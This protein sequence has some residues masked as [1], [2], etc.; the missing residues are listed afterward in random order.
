MRRRPHQPDL[1]IVDAGLKLEE[2]EPHQ[3]L[4][5]LRGAERA[6]DP[7]QFFLLRAATLH[8]LSRFAEAEADALRSLAVAPDVATTHDLL[9]RVRDHLGDAAGAAEAAEHAAELDPEEFPTPLEIADE[10]FDAMVETAI[11]ELPEKV[12]S[13]LDEVPVLVQSLPEAAMLTGEEPPLSPDILG[14]FVGR[15]LLTEASMPP[16][17]PGA[18]YIFRRNLARACDDREELER[19]VRITLRHEVGH[20]L[21]LDEDE[22]ED[23]G[24]A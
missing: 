14:L 6:A 21:G 12:R 7:A 16:G 20:L 11:A 4:A 18:I 23:W 10:D 3:A 15:H 1:R 17:A 19:E 24:L 8:E 5:A 22:L 13:E 2:G 9:S